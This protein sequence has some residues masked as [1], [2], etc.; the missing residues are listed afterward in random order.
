MPN[1]REFVKTIAGAA[2]VAALSPRETAAQP[3][4][5]AAAGGRRQV[6]I[7]G[8]RMKVIDV[9]AH[10]VIPEVAAVVKGTPLERNAAGTRNALSPAR[11]QDLDK[12]GIDV[13][14]LSINGYWW[15]AADRELARQI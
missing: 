10:C 4:L 6:S 13:Q 15:Y 14:A 7:G 5:Q 2:A 3:R 1:C 9:H 12:H 11:L 8:R